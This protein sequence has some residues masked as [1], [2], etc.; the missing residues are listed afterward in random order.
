M[1]CRSTFEN[2]KL[3]AVVAIFVACLGPSTRTSLA[4]SSAA[5]WAEREFKEIAPKRLP[6]N[7]LVSV[8][9]A[10][11]FSDDE[12]EKGFIAYFNAFVFPKVTTKAGRKPLGRE[13]EDIV[14]DLHNV[15]AK[16]ATA[17]NPQV[18]NKLCEITLAY[19]QKVAKND[20]TLAEGGQFHPAA[21]VTAMLAIAE[22]QPQQSIP[23]LLA[24]VR[25]AKQ[26]DAV[27]VA[28]MSGL[29]Q[30]ATKKGTIANAGTEP[31]VVG[32]M[33]VLAGAAVPKTE[34]ADAIRWMRGQAAEVLASLGKTGQNNSVPA[35]LLKIAADKDLGIP[36]RIK[37]VQAIGKLDYG[38]S[39]L[40]GSPYVAA[41]A[42]IAR[43]ALSED[44]PADR[45]RVKS[46]ARE[47]LASLKIVGPWAQ[48]KD[49]LAAEKL[50]AVVQKLNDALEPASVTD[51][52]VKAAIEAARTSV[53]S[54]KK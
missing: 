16:A 49:K 46:V 43:E 39:A 23:I 34:R 25:D 53:G 48:G 19:M 37:A 28:A 7:G 41:F 17:P 10:G 35:A 29:V 27:R 52:A 4:Q 54:I 45:A 8:L 50:Q 33:V 13:N 30:F 21:R 42:D 36:I 5:G 6:F 31:A 22:V 11:T 2:T 26:L 32:T 47:L 14:R 9:Q 51:T 1:F 18:Y 38:N 24:T 12:E 15:L 20:P 40:E 3:W 44:K